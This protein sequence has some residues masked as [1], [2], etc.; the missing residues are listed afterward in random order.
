MA[1]IRPR[2]DR[3]VGSSPPEDGQSIS[4]SSIKTEAWADAEQGDMSMASASQETGDKGQNAAGAGG[5]LKRRPKAEQDKRSAKVK[6][7]DKDAPGDDAKGK[8]RGRKP[9]PKENPLEG[10][11]LPSS[12]ASGS[13]MA[14]AG[15]GPGPGVSVGGHVGTTAATMAG[16]TPKVANGSLKRQRPVDSNDGTLGR[17][18]ENGIHREG[19]DSDQEDYSQHKD[20]MTYMLEVH[21]R[22]QKVQRA[23][24]KQ[25]SVCVHFSRCIPKRSS[26]RKRLGNPHLTLVESSFYIMILA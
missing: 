8:K 11:P 25:A 15:V 20:L 7:D 23:Y 13:S 5:Q 6:M 10:P 19:S 17:H 1:P 3:K 16:G 2:D 12:L 18:D 14:G 22:G 21:K 4:T 26:K 24:E 9:K